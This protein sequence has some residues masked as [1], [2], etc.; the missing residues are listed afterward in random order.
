MLKKKTLSILTASLFCA[1]SLFAQEGPA[2]PDPEEVAERECERLESLL[3]LED[4][5][6]FYVDSTLRN[7]LSGM[8][9]ELEKMQRSRIENTDIYMSV[10]DKWMEMTQNSYKKIFN[11]EQWAAYLRS[12]GARII[13]DREKR[14]AKMEGKKK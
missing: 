5:Q 6:V 4:W 14:R 13:K 10:Q 7:D 8:F 12:G 1:F 9:A 11:E 3:N 2:R